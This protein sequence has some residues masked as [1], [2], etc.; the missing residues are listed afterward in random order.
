MGATFCLKNAKVCQLLD[1]FELEVLRTDAV[2]AKGEQA[3][4]SHAGK[5]GEALRCALHHLDGVVHALGGDIDLV[6]TL[7]SLRTELRYRMPRIYSEHVAIRLDASGFLLPFAHRASRILVAL[8]Q[9]RSKRHLMMSHLTADD[10]G[11]HREEVV[12]HSFS[13]RFSG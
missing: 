10:V 7:T 1:L 4:P 8:L 9:V 3:A 6:V 11:V 13:S 2:E 12:A 5:G